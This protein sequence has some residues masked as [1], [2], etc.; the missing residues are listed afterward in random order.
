[1]TLS[2]SQ[3]NGI[4]YTLLIHGGILIFLMMLKLSVYM[5]FKTD[6][7]LLVDFGYS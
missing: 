6:E 7:G 4:I 2:V 1:M 3:R 5:A